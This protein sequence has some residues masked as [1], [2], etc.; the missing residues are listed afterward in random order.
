NNGSWSDAE[1][2]IGGPNDGMWFRIVVDDTNMKLYRG[3]DGETWTL[4]RTYS[5]SS[6]GI[7]AVTRYGFIAHHYNAGTTDL[8]TVTKAYSTEFPKAVSGTSNGYKAYRLRFDSTQSA[9]YASIGEVEFRE[10][11]GI[12]QTATGGT[13]FSTATGNGTSPAAAFDG[14]TSSRWVGDYPDKPFPKYVGYIYATAK[15]FVQAV[16]TSSSG[17]P[18]EAPLTYGIEASN[19]TTTGLDG[20]WVE[21]A[22]VT[23]TTNW[24]DGEKRTLT[25]TPPSTSSAAGASKTFKSYRLNMYGIQGGF[26]YAFSELAFLDSSGT[27]I[28]TTGATITA[29]GTKDAGSLPASN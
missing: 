14:D 8:T 24:T 17:Y 26:G 20:T 25:L 12:T 22:K 28:P 1:Y 29:S 10:V 18:Q 15:T 23:T 21:L 5:L 13:A 9:S 3:L 6:H 7:G 19:D 27:V 16:L 2:D 4:V 11:A